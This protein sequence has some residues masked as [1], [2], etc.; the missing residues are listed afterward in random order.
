MTTLSAVAQL[1]DLVADLPRFNQLLAAFAQKLHLDLPAFYADHI[2]LRCHQ[3]ATADRWREGFMQCATL[4]N[5]TEINGRPICLFTLAQPLAVGPWQIDV[6]EL[7]YPGDKRYPHEGWEH[8]ELVLS[9]GPQDFY[10]RALALLADEA[11]V[12][13]GIK[14]KQSAPQGENERLPNPTLAITDGTITIKFHPYSLR[15]IVAS[16]VQPD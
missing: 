5:E 3:N 13:P 1:Q 6:I 11:L 14:I 2:S 8:V 16:E 15:E 4:L 12:A 7:P 9:G 10:P